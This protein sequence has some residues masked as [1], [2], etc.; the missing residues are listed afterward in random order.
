MINFIFMKQ[1]YIYTDVKY[2]ADRISTCALNHRPF[3][4][5]FD[6]E[7]K[8]ALFV[9]DPLRQ[10]HLLFRTP[11]GGNALLRTSCK[12]VPAL[13][14]R[15]EDEGT[16]SH[17]FDVVM[18]AL[19]RGD[20]FLTNLTVRTPVESDWTLR[21][22]FEVAY[23]P[24]CLYYPD[25][26]VCFSPE[27]FVHVTS[28][29]LISTDPMKGTISA[30]IPD[31][32]TLILSDAK[33][34]AEHAT[35]VDLLR[36]DLSMNAEKVTVKRYRYITRVGNGNRA[37]LQ[38]SS[39]IQGQLP[40]AWRGRLGKVLLD[41]LPAGSV[42]GA[43]KAATLRAIRAAEDVDRGFYTG[44]FGYYDGETLDSAVMIRF[45][46]QDSCGRLFYRS[47]G[48]I[49]AKSLMK[50]EY[51]EI[52]QKIYIPVEERLFSDVICV[53]DGEFLRLDYHLKRI[54]KTCEDF[55]PSF[56]T[57]ISLE[58][59]REQLP[60]EAKQGWYK[61][62][63]VY[64]ESLQSVEFAAYHPKKVER[65]SLVYDDSISYGYKYLDR[66]ALS[67]CVAKGGTDDVIIV[68]NGWVT[69][70]SFCNL[71]FEEESGRLFTPK[72]ALLKGTYRQWLLDNGLVEEKSI[73]P[74]DLK[75]YK[76]VYFVN[77]MRDL[78]NCTQ[79]DVADV[80]GAK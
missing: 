52:M 55:F 22:I 42:S 70:S 32:Q 61:C 47:G 36:N 41:M 76:K 3:L 77:A 58:K 4:F 23:A 35:V 72:E 68:K 57:S 69:D 54:R 31:A 51:N 46:E 65:V 56:D 29:G 45:I 34:S 50:N 80:M 11:L 16:Y 78:A 27:R 74:S 49:T 60:D 37:I 43:P 28:D 39:E 63:I 66:S 33:E 14:P 21:Q 59:L 71:V 24:Y 19:R 15:V 53:R 64:G 6:F 13:L 5:A 30:A 25:G 20:S 9:E 62:R 67:Q 10:T 40:N 12:D 79:M 26:F 2:V 73:D 18:A 1:P 8:Q 44:V 48:G 17:R 75:S 7:L 38:V